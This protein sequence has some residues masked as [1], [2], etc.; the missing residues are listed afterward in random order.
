M[1]FRG[2]ALKSTWLLRYHFVR[3]GPLGLIDRSGWSSLRSLK[4]CY[5]CLSEALLLDSWRSR[6]PAW[7]NRFDRF[8]WRTWWMAETPGWVCWADTVGS[9][10][11]LPLDP[12]TRACWATLGQ[13]V[14][15][16]CKGSPATFPPLAQDG[17][18]WKGVWVQVLPGRAECVHCPCLGVWD[19][20]HQL[21]ELL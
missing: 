17:C 14:L 21:W 7:R 8:L 12:R 9:D 2:G 10:W 5:H 13:S 11:T 20:W 6:S 3:N 19:R 16:C 4:S 1:S 15:S 18:R